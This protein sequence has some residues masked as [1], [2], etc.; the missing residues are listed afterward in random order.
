MSSWCLDFFIRTMETTAVPAWEL[1]SFCVSIGAEQCSW[2]RV[3]MST[4]ECEVA[5]LGGGDLRGEPEVQR[6]G[7]RRRGPGWGGRRLRTSCG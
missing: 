2:H 4:G 1:A 5:V 6:A 7:A 3:G